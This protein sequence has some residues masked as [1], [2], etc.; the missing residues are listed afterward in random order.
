LRTTNNLTLCTKYF[1]LMV[2][3]ILGK[4]FQI[5]MSKKCKN[6]INK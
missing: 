1:Q 3:K 6:E 5:A 2:Y 4:S